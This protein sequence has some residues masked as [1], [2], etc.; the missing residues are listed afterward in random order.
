MEHLPNG[1]RKILRQITPARTMIQFVN[2]FRAPLSMI[3]EN[4]RKMHKYK[5][6]YKGR[7]CFI[8]G[9]GPSLRAEDLDRIKGEYSFASNKIYEIYQHTDWRPTF[10]CN[11][12]DDL[13]L[14]MGEKLFDATAQSQASFFR[15]VSYRKLGDNM[16]KLHNPTFVPI[17]FIRYNDNSFKFS[18]KADH[19]LGDCGT[20]TYMAMQL[21]AF[22]GFSEIYL[23]GVDHSFPFQRN[24]DGKIQEIDLSL[25]AHFYETPEDNL[26]EHGYYGH[27]NKHS[28]VTMGYRSAEAF[29]RKD[30][31]F[32]IYNA[33]RGGKLEE[34]ERVDFDEVV[35]DEK[36]EPHKSNDL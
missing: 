24:M 25:A 32:R 28:H 29:S 17:L 11:Q 10:Y 12:D 6:V 23:L 9:N 19:F 36:T 27:A 7:R 5:D 30:G 34:F 1:L 13:F 2:A 4:Q 35:R 3:V 16:V 14:P 15:L 31:S 20:V 18:K 33:T 8:I 22:M 21:A 26:G